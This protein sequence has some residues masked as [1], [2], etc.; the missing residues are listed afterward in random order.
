MQNVTDKIIFPKCTLAKLRTPCSADALFNTVN[1]P[2]QFL[3]CPT[4]SFYITGFHVYMW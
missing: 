3:H 1:F 4:L 2:L